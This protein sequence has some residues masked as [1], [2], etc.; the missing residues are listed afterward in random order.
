MSELS[1]AVSGARRAETEQLVSLLKTWVDPAPGL[2]MVQLHYAWTRPG[3]EPDWD[4][5]DRRVL[6]PSRHSPGLRT[7]VI[8][9]PRQLG[10][11]RDYHLHHFFFAVGGAETSTSP[12]VTEEIVAREVTYTDESGRWTHVGIGWGVTP[13]DPE[14]PAPNYTAAAMDGLTFEDAGAGAPPEPA[15]IH[16]F[17][18]AQPLPHVFRG[19]VW[20]PRG[21]ELRYVFHLVRAGSPR[22]EDDTETWD[23]ADG[24]GWVLTL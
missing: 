9:V 21:S 20:G 6:T 5:G 12:I 22:P 15:P 7:A 4:A 2:E 18:R 23:Y 1:T 11:S 24:S 14:P 3:E 10:G 8:E 17:V 16:E 13:G 19:L